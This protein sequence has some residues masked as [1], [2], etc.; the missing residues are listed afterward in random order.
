MVRI[1][2]IVL[3]AC[4]S[5]GGH[6]GRRVRSASWRPDLG[7]IRFNDCAITAALLPVT[8]RMLAWLSYVCNGL[9]EFQAGNRRNSSTV[10]GG[11]LVERLARPSANLLSLHSGPSVS[12]R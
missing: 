4:Y 2:R 12:A 1:R 7:D 6:R 11:D 9:A 8:C 5:A 3:Y 10:I